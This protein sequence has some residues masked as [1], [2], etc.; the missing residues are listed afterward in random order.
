M[1]STRCAFD[2]EVIHI[3]TL[4]NERAACSISER[5]YISVRLTNW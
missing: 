5:R 3:I 1:D 4:D 2:L